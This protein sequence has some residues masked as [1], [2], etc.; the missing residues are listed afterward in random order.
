MI[1]FVAGLL[2]GGFAVHL[3]HGMTYGVLVDKVHE[4]FDKIEAAA[5]QEVKAAI[6]KIKEIL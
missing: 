4:E 1:A 2:I 6:A 5:S 3:L